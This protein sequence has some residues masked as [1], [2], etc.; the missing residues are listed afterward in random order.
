M[1]QEQLKALQAEIANLQ[2]IL[3]NNPNLPKNT[4]DDI[5]AK[6]DQAKNQVNYIE[7]NGVVSKEEYWLSK[8]IQEAQQQRQA[9]V[10][11]EIDAITS[12]FN[13][14]LSSYYNNFSN[15]LKTA[16]GNSAEGIAAGKHLDSTLAAAQGAIQAIVK[17]TA[18][19]TK[20]AGLSIYNNDT[21]TPM[22]S[23]DGIQNKEYTLRIENLENL[24]V[25][26]L[27]NDL[28]VGLN[29]IKNSSDPIKAEILQ[30]VAENTKD[31][32]VKWDTKLIEDVN[33][34]IDKCNDPK[35]I[36]EFKAIADPE[37]KLKLAEK[38]QKSRSLEESENIYK[39]YRVEYQNNIGVA[40][41]KGTISLNFENATKIGEGLEK[42]THSLKADFL[43][44]IGMDDTTIV[45]G[46]SSK[47]D[48]EKFHVTLAR[49]VN[50][51]K[52]FFEV[53]MPYSEMEW[54]NSR[55]GKP[56]IGPKNISSIQI[57]QVESPE[58]AIN[59]AMNKSFG[60]VNTPE[61][62][63]L[64]ATNVPS[65]GA[66]Q[67]S[68]AQVSVNQTSS[69]EVPRWGAAQTSENVVPIQNQTTTSA[70]INTSNTSGQ[71]LAANYK[72]AEPK[73]ATI[74]TLTLGGKPV[75]KDGMEQVDI[76]KTPLNA[77]IEQNKDGAFVVKDINKFKELVANIS[78]ARNLEVGFNGKNYSGKYA[79]TAIEKGESIKVARTEEAQKEITKMESHGYVSCTRLSLREALASKIPTPT[80][81]VVLPDRAVGMAQGS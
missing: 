59:A 76:S 42:G 22:F 78:D 69:T 35:L 36:E 58:I 63:N 7:G 23:K 18:D 47:N 56:S 54:G 46:S 64:S 53:T 71:T 48:G 25:K 80:P 72:I 62:N 2:A 50:G 20:I 37:G 30:R 45:A 49:T 24:I 60:G 68:A 5:N 73:E 14:G 43:K 67:V 8:Q 16:F 3:A 19:N 26:D 66:P 39:E 21:S 32:V 1:N 4:V 6:L 74:K 13:L 27:K 11:A 75:I 70:G 34:L 51:E 28:E 29:H 81:E 55:D 41:G 77:A 17:E 15:E 79:L 10:N 33:Q 57:K 31:G 44:T 61:Q 9:I 65:W 52:Q 12:N 40:L 38:L